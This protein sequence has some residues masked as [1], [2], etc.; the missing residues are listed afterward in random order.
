MKPI[1]RLSRSFPTRLENIDAFCGEARALLEQEGLSGQ[2]FPVELLVREAMTNAM[3][4]GNRLQEDK[5]VSVSLSLRPGLIIIRVL[6]EG[7]GFDWSSSRA[8]PGNALKESGRGLKIYDHYAS[9][10][11]FNRK[12]NGVVLSRRITRRE[13][14]G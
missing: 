11:M 14:H 10:V 12:G 13:E 4:H 2:A 1:C 8:C 5:Q 9:R 6:D 3:A 7:Q